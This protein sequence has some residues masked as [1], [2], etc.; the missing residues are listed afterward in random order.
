MPQMFPARDEQAANVRR[1]PGK[2]VGLAGKFEW[3]GKE[4]RGPQNAQNDGKSLSHGNR[5]FFPPL[6]KNTR[7]QDLRRQGDEGD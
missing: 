6:E 7:D 1:H 2:P 3:N 4:E 5:Q